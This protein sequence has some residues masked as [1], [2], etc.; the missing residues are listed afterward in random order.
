[1]K[2][3][4][5]KQT[6]INYGKSAN[7]P[8]LI[9]N[10]SLAPVSIGNKITTR[11]PKINVANSGVRVQHTEYIGEVF[12]SVNFTSNAFQINPGVGGT[13]PWLSLIAGLYESYNFRNLQFHYCTQKA[14]TTNG[15]VMMAVDF[16]ANDTAPPNK[17]QVMAYEGAVRCQPWVNEV[18]TCSRAGL[19]VFKNRYVRLATVAN[20]DLKT[21]DVGTF[22]ICTQGNA[23]T[24]VLG[25]LYVTY[26]IEFHTP[27]YNTT[28]WASLGSNR[29]TGTTGITGALLL[30]T[31]PT[32][33]VAGSGMNITYSTSTGVFGFT[34]PGEYLVVYS[35]TT[36]AATTGTPSVALTG[37][38]QVST[39]S[40]A[41]SA[42]LALITFT[43]SIKN[44]GDTMTI[45]GI[46]AGTSPNNAQL[47]VASYPFGL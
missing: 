29:S 44:A 41:Y 27:Q 12:G 34:S 28:G 42:N 5:Q 24:S 43:V 37:G 30:G 7:L 23:D 16:D 4:Q 18:Y 11:Q 14:T 13:F 26:D 36:S 22:Y 2:R 38:S 31:A 6:R 15:V 21:F 46:T 1:M 47:R 17:L 3:L 25:E 20:T 45:T 40:A 8:S 19:D 39:V 33:N 35:H 10:M 32:L 9:E